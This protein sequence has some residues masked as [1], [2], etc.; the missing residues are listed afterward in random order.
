MTNLFYRL[1]KGKCYVLAFL[2]IAVAPFAFGQISQQT[3]VRISSLE[4]DASAPKTAETGAWKWTDISEHIPH[5]TNRPIWDVA[6]VEDGWLFTDGLPFDEGGF[7]V[8]TDG[9]EYV[10]ITEA[11]EKNGLNQVD[12]IVES[13]SKTS[14]VF[15]EEIV[16]R[17]DAY[18][19]LYRHTSSTSNGPEIIYESIADTIKSELGEQ[20]IAWL[21]VTDAGAAI[22]TTNGYPMVYA[23]ALG[24]NSVMPLTGIV[25]DFLQ[26]WDALLERYPTLITSESDLKRIENVRTAVRDIR[27]NTPYDD[28]LVYSKRKTS[29]ADS[30]EYLP[31]ASA[32]VRDDAQLVAMRGAYA[33]TTE[34]TSFFLYGGSTVFTDVT[35]DIGTI[36]KLHALASSNGAFLIA[37]TD[38]TTETTNKVLLYNGETTVDLSEKAAAALP[39][40]TWNR[41][42]IAYNGISWLI[43]SG[44][45]LV[46]FDGEDFENLGRTRDLF[47]TLTGADGAFYLGGVVSRKDM[48]EPLFPLQAKLVI[49]EEAG[50]A[51]A[52]K[53][54]TVVTE[55]EA[56]T[57]EISFDS[58]S[59]MNEPNH[60]H[61]V[62]AASPDGLRQI[63]VYS[64]D[65][66][67]NSCTFEDET[68][69][70]YCYFS[71]G[72]ATEPN[73]ILPVHA[74][75]TD[76][77]G[78]TAETG[79]K[80]F[81]I[82]DDE[83]D[84]SNYSASYS[85]KSDPQRY[86]ISIE[87]EE[88]LQ[89]IEIYQNFELV[90]TCDFNYTDRT[91][92][93][94]EYVIPQDQDNLLIIP[95]VISSSGEFKLFGYQWFNYNTEIDEPSSITEEETGEPMPEPESSEE[96]EMMEESELIDPEPTGA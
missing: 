89:K 61:Y 67:L 66:I 30:A 34:Q 10:D 48:D 9:A 53:E 12:D 83:G 56:T 58:G 37:G 86:A 72:D 82:V 78:A 32:W 7:V 21:G 85:V 38:G 1:L 19:L 71:P 73:S 24:E 5:R 39:F 70:K 76:S 60:S 95:K 36:Q 43:L 51:S 50:S 52:E 20:G 55:V 79:I 16:T 3:G 74:I 81:I 75:A 2:A 45:H 65:T 57:L 14:A 8:I 96:P 35:D 4:S 23:P 49:V 40:D 22:Y 47:L 13:F 25:N 91:P 87:V 46:R 77:M 44:K 90:K 27:P 42:Q 54:T 88:G 18:N 69:Y 63:D 80:K 31:L 84:L 62:Q 28:Q 33:S 41:V 92:G 94:C 59:S 6:R 29:P 68:G 17:S 15:A 93:E 64:G 26:Q 11:L